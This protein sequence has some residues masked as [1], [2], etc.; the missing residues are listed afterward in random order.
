MTTRPPRL[1]R[2]EPGPFAP[3]A[4]AFR[5]RVIEGHRRHVNRGMARLA[6]LMG[7]HVEVRSAGNYVFDER[8]E[9]YL[10]CGGYGVFTLGHCHPAVVR[11]VTEQIGRLPLSTRSMVNPEVAAAAEALV[12]ATPEGL[13]YVYF[14]SSGAE[15]TEAAIKLA[16]LNGRTGLIAM[17]GGYHGKTLGALSVTGRQAYR[18]PFGSL[19]APAEFVRFGDADELAAALARTGAT[20]CV[21]LEPVQAEGGVVIPPD[22]YL[23]EVERLCRHHGAYL[24]LDEIQ[25]GLGRLGAWWGL[26]RENVA[27]DLLLVGKALSGGIVPVSAL[28]ATGAAFEKLNQAPILHTSTFSGNPLAAAAARATVAAI[29]DDNVVPRA[30]ALGE[31]LLGQLGFLLS[32]RSSRLVRDVRGRGI[33]IGLEFGAE[34]LAGDFM[35]EML[36]RNVVVSYSLNAHR[37]VRLTPSAFLSEGDVQWL[38]AAAREVLAVLDERYPNFAGQQET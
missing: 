30:R 35:I 32:P 23:R 14:G 13:D 12:A 25:T 10:D 5:S 22:G 38:V 16:C 24:I 28:V 18:Q 29:R 33:L 26:E 21:I 17:H 11:A 3:D 31:T 8:G 34:F 4:A 20:G 7:T 36:K 19:L 15:A 1:E 9:R 2:Q 6:D 27:P 37:V